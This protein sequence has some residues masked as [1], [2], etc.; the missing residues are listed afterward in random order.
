MACLLPAARCIT[1]R[2]QRGAQRRMTQRSLPARKQTI[3][4]IRGLSRR[5]EPPLSDS[6]PC[7]AGARD[8]PRRGR[9]AAAS[10]G[11]RTWMGEAPH[12]EWRHRRREAGARNRPPD[13]DHAGVSAAGP[14]P[15]ARKAHPAAETARG[16]AGEAGAQRVGALDLD[17]GL[18]I[19]TL[20]QTICYGSDDRHEGTSA[21]LE[22]RKPR[23]RGR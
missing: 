19:E 15:G 13:C 18:L 5:T 22:K 1:S 6:H 21:F 20:A 9:H 10:T 8:H 14:R 16:P 23:F 17:S 4:N 11:G 12:P 7:H 2:R 3:G